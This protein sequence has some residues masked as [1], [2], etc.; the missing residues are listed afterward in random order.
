MGKTLEKPLQTSGLEHY[1]KDGKKEGRAR[2]CSQRER[3]RKEKGEQK[4]RNGKWQS[5]HIFLQSNTGYKK[6]VQNNAICK[7]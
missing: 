6:H 5:M 7:G 4:N 1:L 3:Q 2:R